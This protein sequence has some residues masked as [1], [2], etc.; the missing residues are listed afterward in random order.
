MIWSAG[1]ELYDLSEGVR[2]KVVSLNDWNKQRKAGKA[3][4]SG[5]PIRFPDMADA[6]GTKSQKAYQASKGG[7]VISMVRDQNKTLV[8]N[9]RTIIEELKEIEENTREHGK[10]G[11]K[12]IL[13]ALAGA[14]GARALGKLIGS[15]I[16]SGL[17]AALGGK[18]I[19]KL[20]QRL[21]GG[22]ADDGLPLPDASRPGTPGKTKK[23]KTPKKLKAAVN[24]PKWPPQLGRP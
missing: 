17:A 14:I 21:I 4:V 11:G 3:T 8:E 18:T 22:G 24:W 23:P 13:G 19:L 7:S 2:E 16:L 15:R 1:K 12:G 10:S 20:L 9:D 6:G 5:D